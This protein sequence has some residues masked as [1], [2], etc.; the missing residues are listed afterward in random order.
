ML[1][2]TPID[3]RAALVGMNTVYDRPDRCSCSVTPVCWSNCVNELREESVLTLL[4]QSFS[5]LPRAL[6]RAEN[7]IQRNDRSREDSCN[8]NSFLLSIARLIVHVSPRTTCITPFFTG[9]FDS[10]LSMVAVNGREFSGRPVSVT[11]AIEECSHARL[12]DDLM[13]AYRCRSDREISVLARRT[14]GP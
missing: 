10:A 9:M 6:Y 8:D 12:L 13:D 11:T 5:K 7:E 2:V 4:L 14:A 3:C 1:V